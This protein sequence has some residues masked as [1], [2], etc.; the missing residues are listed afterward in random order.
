MSASI[1]A[2]PQSGKN[3]HRL[4]WAVMTVFAFLT[5][6]Y[7][8]IFL[9]GNPPGDPVVKQKMLSS[10]LGY[11]HVLGGMLA[12]VIGPFQFLGALRRRHVKLH[13]LLGSIYLTAV[14]LSALCAFQ[15]TWGSLAN[16][17]GDVGFALLATAWLLTGIQAFRAI[18]ARDFQSHRRWMIRNYSLT[19]AAVM[20]RWQLPVLILAGGVEPSLA[21]S[22]T[23]FSCW[24]PNLLFAE[25][26]IRRGRNIP[27]VP[28]VAA[29]S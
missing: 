11:I 16:I 27:P 15:L 28:R 29:V 17:Y 1:I 19:Y 21:L 7:T 6:I 26:W 14:M 4:G 3:K 22:I 23:G 10:P 18:Q 5:A 24:I 25:W 13:R 12:M 8:L 9:F 2:S 20:L